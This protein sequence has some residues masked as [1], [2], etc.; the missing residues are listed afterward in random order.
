MISPSGGD[1]TPAI[2]AAINTQGYAELDAG[3]FQVSSL[4]L[5]NNQGLSIIGRSALRTTIIPTQ[6]GVNV[7]DCTGSSNTL[8]RDFRINGIGQPVMPL[9]GILGAQ[10]QG[11][12][13]SDVL[14][15]ENVRV[16]GSFGLAPL[17]V[18]GVQSSRII[19]GQ[20]YQY[21]SGAMTAIFTGNNFFGATSYFVPIS[22]ANNM[23]VSDWTFVACEWHN[24]VSNWALWMGG[25]QQGRFYG[26]NA[27]SSG[28]IVSNNAVIV[29]GATC[30]PENVIFDGVTFYSDFAPVAPV[31][32][33]GL[34][35]AP[36]AAFRN[37]K[38]HGMP[39]T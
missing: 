15:I 12:A 27:S 30:Y 11:S 35:A 39:L 18:Y 28:P 21:A 38:A 2:Q 3:Q 23:E 37:C 29:N 6:S 31:A 24:M 17:F 4:D 33:S 14:A 34:T 8:L 19:G 22:T 7:I 16:E 20:F 9:T 26:G 10:M 32:V 1:D 25:V 13:A 5:T 36:Y